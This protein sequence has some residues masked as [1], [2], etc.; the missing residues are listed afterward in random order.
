LIFFTLVISGTI[1]INVVLPSFGIDLRGSLTANEFAWS[2]VFGFGG[3]FISLFMSKFL[4]KRAYRMQ[5]VIN[6]TTDKEKLVYETV[7]HLA[8]R[9][10][11]RMPEVWV[12]WD[13]A[14]NAFATGPTRNNAMVA[15]SSGLVMHMNDAEVR[16]VLAHEVGHVT[17]GDMLA[18]TLL[19]G[20]MNTFVYFVARMIARPI[21]ERNY[22]AGFAV[23]MVLQFVLSILAMIPVT[24][25]SR[26]REFRADAYAASVVGAASM[27][28]ALQKLEYL[29]QRPVTQEE[30]AEDDALATMKIY[31][32]HGKVAGLFATHPPI[33]ARIEAL[34]HPQA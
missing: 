29:S 10:G 8:E 9:E 7:A 14:P 2:L 22:W 20:L 17:N 1:L 27:I 6:P 12:Y 33:Q 31:A 30:P 3:A 25:F 26:R 13:D 16:A 5:Q 19:Q 15:V 23:Y 34:R 21:M 4:A 24:W 18:S 28:S 11:I 32:A